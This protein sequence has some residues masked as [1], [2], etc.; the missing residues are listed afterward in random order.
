MVNCIPKLGGQ[1][2]LEWGGQFAPKLMVN[3]HWNRVVNLT[4]FS[5]KVQKKQTLLDFEEKHLRAKKLIEGRKPNFFIGL[6][7]AQKTGQKANYTKNK[8]FDKQ[9]YLDLIIKSIKEHKEV[10]RKDIDELLWNKLPD[11]MDE[12]QKKNKVGNLIRELRNNNK[13]KNSGTLKDSKWV[14]IV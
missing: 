4:G 8:G 11:W 9:Y 13:I 14:L 7:V 10:T 3:L 1:F 6:G 5:N 2:E 12:K